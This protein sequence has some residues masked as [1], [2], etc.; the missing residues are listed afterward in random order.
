MIR[1]EIATTAPPD[2]G[3]F[4][5]R[6]ALFPVGLL[7]I[8]VSVQ[9][10]LFT[11]SRND[12]SFAVEPEYYQKAVSW[13]QQQEQRQ[14]NVELGWHTLVALEQGPTPELKVQLTDDAGKPLVQARVTA[15]AFANARAALVQ[16]LT[17]QEAPAGTYTTPLRLV[18]P[19]EWE[20]RLNVN[21]GN[22]TFTHVVRT[23]PS[24][25]R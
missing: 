1:T 19:G 24:A 13:D 15:V 23:V 17:L 12:P 20:I 4:P 5:N 10:V 11:L 16:E 8:L 25:T 14:T 9:L 7:A 22:Q 6:W 2:A 21:H 3:R 18:H